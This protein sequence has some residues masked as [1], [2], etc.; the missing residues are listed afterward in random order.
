MKIY[1]LET[2]DDFPSPENGCVLSIGNF[3]GVHVGHQS[4]IQFARLMATGQHLPMMLM[5]F[6]PTAARVLRPEQ[7]QQILTPIEL[8]TQLL[9]EQHPDSL[10]V[11]EPTMA[12]LSLSSEEF[13]HLM[14]DKLRMKHLVEGETFGFG[15]QREGKPN[16]LVELANKYDFKA[17]F[18]KTYSL[19]LYNEPVNDTK[20]RTAIQ[21]EVMVTSTLIRRLILENE[22]AKVR[23][24]LG[25]DYMLSGR[26][27]SGRGE[28]RKL[29]F[30]TANLHLDHPEQ[31]VP[32]DGVYAGRAYLGKDCVEAW[33]RPPLPAA[34]SIGQCETYENG[35]W[36][37]EAYLLDFYPEETLAGMYMLLSFT[38]FIRAQR[39][40]DSPQELAEAIDKDISAIRRIL[41]AD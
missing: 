27:V 21:D 36:Q 11:V 14:K 2:F 26:I 1:Y 29:G 31:L 16:S 34:I 3:D 37:I 18:L 30:P 41:Q 9:A 19:H 6:E 28:G 12:F 24:C 22:L 10:I 23:L 13:I 39:K 15:R 38:E 25:R 32:G 33:N 40:Y 8:K 7:P 4:I 35:I 17:H 20:G 5:T